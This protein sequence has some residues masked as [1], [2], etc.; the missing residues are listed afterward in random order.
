MESEYY[1]PWEWQPIKHMPDGCNE[2]VVRDI[3][4][5]TKE[6][7]SCDYWWLSTDKKELYTTFRF[8]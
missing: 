4:G 7:C 6:M 1:A 8:A 3:E 5:N 2:V